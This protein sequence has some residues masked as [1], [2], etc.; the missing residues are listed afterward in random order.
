MHSGTI[1]SRHALNLETAGFIALVTITR[2]RYSESDFMK[3]VA[4]GAGLPT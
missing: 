4:A 1:V 3:N 2:I